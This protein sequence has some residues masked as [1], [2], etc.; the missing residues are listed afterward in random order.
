MGLDGGLVDIPI[1]PH[2][3]NGFWLEY[4]CLVHAA[5]SL[6]F[7]GKKMAEALWAKDSRLP[8]N[9]RGVFRP[10]GAEPL[11]LQHAGLVLP[12]VVANGLRE[13]FDLDTP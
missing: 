11:V 12:D 9:D 13:L 8:H 6:F 2:P 1:L 4:Q 3:R 7:L 5:P 10:L